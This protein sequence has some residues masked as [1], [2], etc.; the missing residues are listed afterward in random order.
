MKR[1]HIRTAVTL[2]ALI[3]ASILV[4][5]SSQQEHRVTGPAPPAPLQATASQDDI[6]RLRDLEN[7]QNAEAMRISKLPY[8]PPDAAQA[9]AG[10]DVHVVGGT[11]YLPGSALWGRTGDQLYV[12]VEA[13]HVVCDGKLDQKLFNK[14]VFRYRSFEYT[15]SLPMECN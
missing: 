15:Q 1:V 3:P 5:C 12:R 9:E 2:L 4:G 11:L 6:Q 8:M 14:L 10:A 13:L 7:R